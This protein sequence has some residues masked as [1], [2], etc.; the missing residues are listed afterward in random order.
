MSEQTVLF[1]DQRLLSER[2]QREYWL[3]VWAIRPEEPDRKF[4]EETAE[5]KRRLPGLT[6]ADLHALRAAAQGAT[7]RN[8]ADARLE[9]H[10]GPILDAMP[11]SEL[12]ALA[13]EV[14][15]G[16]ALHLFAQKGI[17]PGMARLMLL[18][19]LA[20]RGRVVERKDGP[21]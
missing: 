15:K 7:G 3:L 9:F 13:N 14:L 2:E 11:V 20:R 4:Y 8:A 10:F 21:C 16:P 18:T 17:A 1:P 6:V 19:E 5:I 12:A